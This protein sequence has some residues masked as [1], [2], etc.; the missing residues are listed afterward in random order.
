M[1]RDVFYFGEKPNIHPR[2][3]PATSIEDARSQSTTEHFWI[4]NEF[5]DYS[6]FDWDWDFAF[7]PDGEVWAEEHN[8]VWPST[9]QKDSGTWLC[10]T[11]HSEIMI[12][13]ADVEPL[14]RKKIISPRWTIPDG[15]DKDK[16][17]FSWH[18]DPTSP[19]RIY[20]F[21]TPT[22]QS[23]GPTYTVPDA[24]HTIYL[25]YPGVYVPSINIMPGQKF[26]KYWI[27]TSLADLI[28]RHPNEMFWALNPDLSY[29]DFDFNWVP[30]PDKMQ[31]VHAFG[32]KDNP[33]TQTY[34]VNS[35][36]WL[37]GHQEVNYV[38]D[39]PFTVTANIDMFFIDRSN[40][41]SSARFEAL[42]AKY[43][44]IQKTRYLGS[45]VDT[46]VRCTRK[47][48]SKLCWIL[49]SEL[50]YSNFR[51]DF[52]PNAWQMQM[53][54]IFGTQWGSWGT[55]FMI[56]TDTFAEDT[57]FIKLI[58]H[59]SH[60]N[61]VK[62]STALATNC[63]YDAFLIDHG[64]PETNAVASTIK[65]KISDKNLTTLPARENYLDSIKDMLK[66]LPEKKEHYVWVCSSIC[67]YSNFDF[68]YIC[69]P[70]ARE[71]LHVFPSDDQSYGDTFLIDVNKM[72]KLIGKL[73]A[74]AEYKKINFNKHQKLHR[75][76]SPT[77]VVDSDT[78]VA[79]VMQDFNFP[80][81]TF[82][83]KDN[84]HIEVKS[85]TTMSLW[86]PD[87]KN[88]IVTSTGGTRLI[89]PREAKSFIET[90]L[91][92]YPYVL[93]V[94]DPVKSAPLDIV[95]ISNGE[96]GAEENFKRLED[97]TR[98]L[99]NR[100][101]RVK[102]IDGRVNAYHAAASASKTSWFF[103]VFAKVEVNEKFDWDWQPD[104]LQ[105]TKHYIFHALNPV[106][107][108]EYGHQAVIAYNKNL[109]L[110]NTGVGLDFTMDSPHQVVAVL[111][112]VAR[113][114]TDA[115]STW[116]TAFREAIKL[117]KDQADTSKERLD[118]WLTRAEGDFAE[119]SISGANDAIKYYE[120]V[121]GELNKLMLS[122]DWKWLRSRFDFLYPATTIGPN[123]KRND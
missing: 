103:A 89:V 90:Q 25:A 59:L 118:V 91:Y 50:D 111:S 63:L 46:I 78:H 55:T 102:D 115:F 97:V 99:G 8:N 54:H 114:N 68:T 87:T 34:F 24:T 107:G 81:A 72:R 49:N 5:C 82:V 39:K 11:E 47:S 77:F 52:Y 96:I 85:K 79:S 123:S 71:Q 88:I 26:E 4:V 36:Q 120:E 109:T 106:N 70:F 3:K 65:S 17:D 121:N 83:S 73:N 16:F 29:E 119:Y 66:G 35:P 51:F 21:G 48:S 67:D 12:Y 84:E 57:K 30:S 75:L 94:K 86:S 117:R 62:S 61:F 74:L 9:H 1:L 76:P 95:F 38:G 2:E 32:T 53:V 92:D 60:L 14:R 112:G 37:T 15:F 43:G 27:E 116:R 31:Y 19:P 98:G 7:L 58:E 64:N 23:D 22:D 108:L 10:P 42:K 13:R 104:R 44:K 33:D 28:K 45:W 40:P 100:I 18:P 93:T 41:E 69:D 110:N 122:Y 80:Y 56:N 6:G 101:V 105:A 20:Q 113:Y